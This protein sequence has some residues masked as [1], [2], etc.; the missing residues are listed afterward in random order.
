M[1]SYAFSAIKGGLAGMVLLGSSKCMPRLCAAL[2]LHRR[3]QVRPARAC[4][5]T[6]AQTPDTGTDKLPRQR[7]GPS[8][9]AG[10]TAPEIHE[11]SEPGQ[12]VY[13]TASIRVNAT[14]KVRLHLERC[15]SHGPF[16]RSTD[17]ILRRKE[18]QVY[19][20]YDFAQQHVSSAIPRCN[21]YDLYHS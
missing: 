18:E 14:E 10:Q 16:S 2:S 21:V 15:E 9:G 1:P 5:R 19:N 17:Q 11:L 4:A 20:S 3:Q 7:L 13:G 12:A 8:F 6:L